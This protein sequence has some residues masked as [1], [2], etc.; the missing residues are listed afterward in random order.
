VWR[1]LLFRSYAPS[2]PSRSEG[3]TGSFYLVLKTGFS[4]SASFDLP[5]CPAIDVASAVT[6]VNSSLAETR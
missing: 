3:F 2:Q 5:S 1:N 6:Q 4:M